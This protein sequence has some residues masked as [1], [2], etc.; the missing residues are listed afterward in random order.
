MCLRLTHDAAEKVL[1]TSGTDG[2]FYEPRTQNGREP[3]PEYKVVWLPK[4]N[5]GDALIAK[6]TSSCEV[7]LVRNGMRY[8][9]RTKS[10][11][12][13]SVHDA[14]R[15]DLTFIEG[16]T[17]QTYKVGPLPWGT[18]R[19][20]LNKVLAAWTWHARPGQP[21]GQAPDHSGVIWTVQAASPPGH[22]IYTMTHGDVLISATTAEKAPVTTQRSQVLASAKTLQHI[23]DRA[24]PVS[25]DKAQIDPWLT[26]DPWTKSSIAK[27]TLTNVQLATIEANVTKSLKATLNTEDTP[28]PAEV[29]GRVTALEAQVHQLTSN[30]QSLSSSVNNHQHQ[31]QH[32]NSQ[33]TQQMQSMKQQIDHQHTGLQNM[34]EGKLEEH[35]SKIEALFAKRAKHNE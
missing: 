14:H 24:K 9:L 6:Q 23:A 19:N 32:V 26:S 25:M 33:M 15:P 20:S 30:M 3:D 21:T 1:K 11:N 2:H 35:I 28:M 17:L 16:A 18:T 5:H 12:H 31:Q 4:T 10:T 34:L 29:D 27:P 8:G 22:W 13:K 7:W